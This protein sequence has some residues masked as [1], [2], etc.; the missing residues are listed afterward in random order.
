MKW[1]NSMKDTNYQNSQEKDNIHC[2]VFVKE[3]ESLI[4]NLPKTKS[5]LPCDLTID[6]YQ[7]LSSK[8]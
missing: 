5:S 6:F 4:N 7:N 1:V 2:P 3:I 8:W